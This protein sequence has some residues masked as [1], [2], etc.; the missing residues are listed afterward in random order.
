MY[1]H[2][3]QHPLFNIDLKV[4]CNTVKTK[5]LE[6][7]LETKRQDHLSLQI[8]ILKTMKINWKT[9]NNKRYQ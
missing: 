3:Y 2:Y 4:V 7:E 1:V 5:R 8:N 6:T 9:A